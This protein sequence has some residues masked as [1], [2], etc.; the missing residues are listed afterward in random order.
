ML[1]HGGRG[2]QFCLT[3]K[4]WQA[5]EAAC[6]AD[7]YHLVTIEDQAEQDF[8]FQS[9]NGFSNNKF[10]I[11]LNDLATEGT[12]VWSGGA[13]VGYTNWQAGE[14]NNAGGGEDCAQINRFYPV[15]TWNDEPCNQ[16]LAYICRS[17]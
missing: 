7:G 16:A 3:G 2:Y 1:T 5:A 11:G 15:D 10:W 12:F 4:T 14:P 8:V 6:V 17:N 13:P 9:A